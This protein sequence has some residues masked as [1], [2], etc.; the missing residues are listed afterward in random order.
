MQKKPSILSFFKPNNRPDEMCA[1]G[2][3]KEA[4]HINRY[5]V[6]RFGFPLALW[7]FCKTQ[8]QMLSMKTMFMP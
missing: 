7:E 1:Y 5:W 8:F 6:E 3:V 2:V 4:I